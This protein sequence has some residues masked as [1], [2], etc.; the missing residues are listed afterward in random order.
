M[1]MLK[2]RSLVCVLKS[3]VVPPSIKGGNVTTEVSALINS[4]I[5]LECETRGLPMPVITWYKDGQ[6]VISS[7]QALY[8]EKGQFLH[9][10]RAQVSDSATYKCQVTNVAGT[11]EKSFHVD[12]YGKEN[13]Y[14]FIMCFLPMLPNTPTSNLF[15]DK[16]LLGCIVFY[17]YGLKLEEFVL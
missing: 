1:Q 3:F 10:P 2:L 9:I 14:F 12:I 6:P 4:I 8:V 7:S 13:T 17:I 11:A 16:S 15:T 5:K